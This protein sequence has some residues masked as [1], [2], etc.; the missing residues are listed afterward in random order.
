MIGDTIPHHE[1][2]TVLQEHAAERL[3][4]CGP[5]NDCMSRKRHARTKHLRV[6][7]RVLVRRRCLGGKFEPRF[8]LVPW[9]VVK[10]RGTMITASRLEEFVTCNV[11]FFQALPV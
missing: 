9:T 8:E 7:D 11:S 1:T 6:G 10:A 2:P 4:Q 5:N 3:R